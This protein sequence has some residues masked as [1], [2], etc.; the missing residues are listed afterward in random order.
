MEK[1]KEMYT[2]PS[3]RHLGEASLFIVLLT[4]LRK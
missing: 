4:S 3:L 1:Q 2:L